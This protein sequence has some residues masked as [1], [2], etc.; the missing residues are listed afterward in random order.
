M[1]SFELAPCLNL[2]CARP[3]ELHPGVQTPCTM[4]VSSLDKAPF[5]AVGDAAHAFFYKDVLALLE[6]FR[7]LAL[8]QYYSRTPSVLV[9]EFYAGFFK[10]DPNFVCCTRGTFDLPVH[11]F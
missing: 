10:S 3:P 4:T 8:P 9:D 7:S 1:V 5:A 11:R 6:N 2:L